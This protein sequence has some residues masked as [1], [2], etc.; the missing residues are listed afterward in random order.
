MFRVVPDQLKISDG[1]VRCGHCAD[2]FDA[3][4][5]LE[6]WATMVPP[7]EGNGGA[8]PSVPGAAPESVVS[9]S[10]LDA[11]AMARRSAD[12]SPDVSEA[13]TP[14]D[15]KTPAA[16]QSVEPPPVAAP[17]EAGRTLD[18]PV[19]F[20]EPDP[21]PDPEQ[22]PPFEA[23]AETAHGVDGISSESREPGDEGDWLTAPAP[24][25]E[26]E[27]AIRD[28]PDGGASEVDTV[29]A[30]AVPAAGSEDLVDGSR[31]EPDS[32]FQTDL[33][34]FSASASVA[35]VASALKD[36]QAL[37]SAEKTGKLNEPPAPPSAPEDVTP[38]DPEPGFVRQARRRAFWHS[39][40]MRA[41]LSLFALLL[42]LGLVLQ[43]ALQERD[44][45]AAWQPRLAPALNQV[46]A[47]LGCEVRPVRRIDAIVID[48]SAL[49]RRLGNFYS[50]DLV[51]KNTAPVALAVPAL[52]LSLTDTRD[53]VIARRVFLPEELPGAPALLPAQ[54]SVTISLRL[55]LAVGDAMPMAGYRAL[56]FYP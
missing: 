8:V 44:A 40:G 28:A 31:Q 12:P 52:E 56:V 41:L 6:T 24:L 14:L 27:P 55:S 10:H 49:V 1:W 50:F 37:T 36:A 5:Y 3:T 35:V 53:A 47:P 18:L 46:C 23:A 48:S 11:D 16:D 19:S 20:W 2:V 9:P 51:L 30:G 15:S 29:Q 39:P 17:A 26:E 4:L 7:A 54:D 13:T 25:A 33:Q 45:L 42:A 38:T 34:R 43:W 21:E 22:S 32:D